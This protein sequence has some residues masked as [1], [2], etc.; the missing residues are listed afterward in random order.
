VVREG[1]AWPR[2]L[3]K[4]R[5]WDEIEVRARL[6]IAPHPATMENTTAQAVALEEVENLE[7]RA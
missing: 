5:A 7:A 4:V 2:G 1:K 3:E 6:S